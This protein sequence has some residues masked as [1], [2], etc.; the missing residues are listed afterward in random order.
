MGLPARHGFESFQ[1]QRFRLWAGKACLG[2]LLAGCLLLVACGGAQKHPPVAQAPPPPPAAHPAPQAKA[3]A[4]PPAPAP[5]PSDPVAEVIRQAE[6]SYQAGM[7]DYRAGNLDQAQK[8]FNESLTLLLES[9]PSIPSDPRLGAEFDKLVENIHALEVATLQHGDTLSDQKYVPAPIDSLS[10]LTFPVNPRVKER[11]QEQMHSVHS[12][13]P[14]VSNDL[15]DGVITYFQGRGQGA[16]DKVLARSGLYRPMISRV[17]RKQGLPQDLIYLAGAESAFN[18]FALSRAGAKGI[19]QLMMG[20]AREYG[21]KRTRW[22]DEREDPLKSTEAAA[23]HLKDLYQEFG[24][25]YLAMAAYNCGPGTVKRAIE[26]TGYADF[27]K[28][29]ELHALPRETENYVPIILATALIAKSPKAYGFDVAPDPPIL[30]DSVKVSE[31]TDL[32]LISEL[33]GVPV[34]KLIQLN[35]S[36]LRW[37]TPLDDP[38]FVLHLPAGTAAQYRQ[39]IAQIPPDHRIWWRVHT[40]EAGDTYA[41]IAH[42]YHLS[43]AA[44]RRANQQA[45]DDPLQPGKQV[46]LPLPAG[47]TWSLVRVRGRRFYRYRIRRGDTLGAIAQRFDTTPHDIRRW[48]DMRGSRIIAG[49]TL[50]L[51]VVSDRAG[52][53]RGHSTARGSLTP[54]RGQSYSL[55]RIQPGDT[56]DSIADRFDTTV[57]QIQRWNNMQGSRIVAGHTLRIYLAGDEA[58]PRKHS[59]RQ[60][61]RGSLA[62]VRGHSYSLYRVRRGDTLYGIAQRFGVAVSDLQR[63]NGLHGSLL[64]PGQTLRLYEAGSEAD[65]NSPS[66]SSTAER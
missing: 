34:D 38:D 5:S 8:A 44:L 3:A 55:Y 47:H 32:R 59:S 36:L 2:A 52:G 39:D 58:P 46:V 18:P 63:W 11:V 60:A 35:P 49:H 51:Y 66:S 17:L 45:A 37:T 4:P 7:I 65:K 15:V 40:V 20:R 9:N 61:T 25:W 27:W 13:L 64:T 24:D 42:K 48:N 23:A 30:T 50:R 12:D 29:R 22:V 14:L 31:P 56:L 21:L 57:Y 33:I 43:T 41:S 53:R 28:L 62:P 10:G 1:P 6:S 54:V 16:M 26:R 19:W